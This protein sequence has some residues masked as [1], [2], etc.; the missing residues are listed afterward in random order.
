MAF[1]LI[2]TFLLISLYSSAYAQDF[3]P[4]LTEWDVPDFQAVWK[5]SSIIPLERP[6]E[7]EDRRAYTEA[8]AAALERA[9]QALFEED[10]Q[11]LDP[12]R[13]AP[14][15]D[16]YLPPR[17]PW[18]VEFLAERE[19]DRNPAAEHHQKW[20]GDSIGRW[21]GDTLAVETKYFNPWHRFQGS[22]SHFG[23]FIGLTHGLHWGW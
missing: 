6:P 7:L 2:L 17:L 20:M 12:N 5:H 8:E 4:P 9:E 23:G 21:E 18:I 14:Q 10:A 11:P 22:S 1:R 19:R 15:V 3:E 16:R 13:G